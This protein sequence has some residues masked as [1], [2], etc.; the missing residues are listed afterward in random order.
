MALC[1][2]SIGCMIWRA[3]R[4]SVRLPRKTGFD[5]HTSGLALSEAQGA[6]SSSKDATR[7]GS[8]GFVPLHITALFQ[9][10][11]QAQH[12]AMTSPGGFPFLFTV[13][14]LFQKLA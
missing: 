1:T 10:L 2:I 8:G 7:G 14:Q 9:E 12:L 5:F 3:G 13:F 4:G 6:F 11:V